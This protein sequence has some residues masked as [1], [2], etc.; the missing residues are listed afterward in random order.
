ME[1]SDRDHFKKREWFTVSLN[2]EKSSKIMSRR[3]L[4]L[5][6]WRSSETLGKAVGWSVVTD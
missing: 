3:F 6:I 1:T 2:A 5:K 4:D